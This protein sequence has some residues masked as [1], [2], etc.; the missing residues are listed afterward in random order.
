MTDAATDP[1]T[2]EVSPDAGALAAV[3]VTIEGDK[4]EVI[5]FTLVMFRY[6]DAFIPTATLRPETIH[7]VTNSQRR[8]SH[9]GRQPIAIRRVK[10]WECASARTH[11]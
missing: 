9:S 1:A 2:I 8:G 7:G 4:S 11:Q 5:K 3:E 6:G 10:T